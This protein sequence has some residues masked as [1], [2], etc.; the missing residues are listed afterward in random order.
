[1]PLALEPLHPMTAASRS[2]LNTLRQALD[3]CDELDPGRD[4]G[5]GVAVDVYHVWWDFEVYQQIERTGADRLHTFHLCDWLEPTEDMLVGRGMMGD[6]VID[7]PRLRAAV[8]AVGYTGPCEVEVLS[9]SW[10]ARPIDE[11]LAVAVERYRTVC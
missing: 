9:K 7:I 6:G 4:R 3:L 11:V 2:C 8:E 5:L 1:M 10:W